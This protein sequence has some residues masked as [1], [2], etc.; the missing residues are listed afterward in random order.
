M[1][2]RQPSD[3]AALATALR[4]ILTDD[5]L[6]T[7]VTAR[8]GAGRG[9]LDGSPAG[10]YVERYQGLLDRGRRG[11]RRRPFGC[12]RFGAW[13]PRAMRPA[14]AKDVTIVLIV[15]IVLVVLVGLFAT[16]A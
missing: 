13:V 1:L 12:P 15:L 16:T 8:R 11:G 5:D 10:H 2:L 3:T 4:R 6:A 14:A 9:V 7:R